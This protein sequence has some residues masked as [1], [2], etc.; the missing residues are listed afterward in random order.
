MAI[1]LV[2]MDC[3]YF[4]PPTIHRGSLQEADEQ[5]HAK[6][7]NGQEMRMGMGMEMEMEMAG[8]SG[9]GVVG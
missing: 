9:G 2:M 3:S 6:P 5:Q 7:S 1:D 4:L 8:A